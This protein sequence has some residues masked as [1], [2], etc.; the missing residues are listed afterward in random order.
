MEECNQ[1]LEDF[2]L[3]KQKVLEKRPVLKQLLKKKG[4]KN[5][6]EYANQY[7][8][9]NLNPTIPK[10]Q[11]EFLDIINETV[12]QRFGKKIAQSVVRQLKKYYFISTSDHTG[13][14]TH[15]F[16]VN[17]NLLIAASIL[18][19]QDP[20]LQNIV[21]LSCSRVSVDNSSF[22]RGLFFHNYLNNKLETHRFAFFSSN[23][24][25]PLI[26]TMRPYGREELDQIYGTLDKKL[27]KKEI[28][29]EQYEKIFNI[30]K[31]VYDSPEMLAMPSYTEQISKT[32]FLLWQKFFS[33]SNIK[34]PNLIYLEIEDIVTKLIIKYHL[35]QDTIINHILFD[36][37]YEPYINNYFE[38]IFGSFSR[39]DDAGT[40]L[41]WALPEGARYNLQL[42][43]EG[44]YLV[45]KDGSYKIE[46]TPEAIKA[47]LLKKE[48]IPGLLLDFMV[49]SFYY[50]LKCL[51]GFNQINYLTLMKNSYIKMNVDLENYRSI[52]I[53]ARAQ[54]KE[55]CDGLTVAYVGYNGEK[56]MILASGLDLIL[57]QNKDSWKTLMNL[58][59][60]IT[61]EEAL[62]P[63]LPEIY[64]ITYDQKEWDEKLTKIVDKDITNLN[65]LNKK[66]EPCI[67]IKE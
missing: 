20:D 17:S 10:R 44:N 55:I 29:Q 67:F 31:E 66:I 59:N 47:A 65:G 33:E 43:R 39:Q 27:K 53:C 26:Y 18:Q 21:V 52:E 14:I 34:M 16:F 58:I 42:W 4:T 37:A 13:P 50:G 54:T 2:Q 56:Q 64:K 22:P 30:F 62:E 40:Y 19:H 36:P 51:G 60:N 9:V 24:R 46:L 25:P 6:L 3:L 63:L 61:L 48:L 38:N 32:N 23:T 45:S 15:P 8:D 49:V 11:I 35:N 28:T 12:E 1:L 5:I 57:Y 7:I 41:F